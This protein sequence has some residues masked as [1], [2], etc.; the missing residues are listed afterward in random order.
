MVKFPPALVEECIRKCPSS[1][2]VEARDRK[3][4]LVVG[5][6]TVYF[7]PGPGMSSVDLD[8]FEARTPTRKEFYDAVTVYDALPNIHLHHNNGPFTTFEGVHP[9]MSTIETY[10]ARA[11]NSTKVNFTHIERD[12]K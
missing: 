11:R 10:A 1:F 2:H 5:G 4:D 3:N 7:E 9:L 12:A 6:S 8:T